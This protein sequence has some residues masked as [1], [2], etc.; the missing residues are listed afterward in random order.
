MQEAV[1]VGQ[2]KM[3]AILDQMIVKMQE[4]IERSK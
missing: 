1:P 4:N 3:I 2:G